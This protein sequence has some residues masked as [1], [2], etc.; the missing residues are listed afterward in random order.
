M[1]HLNRILFALSLGFGLAPSLL[2]AQQLS[3]P[4]SVLPWRALQPEV[5]LALNA[6]VKSTPLKSVASDSPAWLLKKARPLSQQAPAREDL[7]MVETESFENLGYLKS[8]SATQETQS[9]QRNRSSRA[10]SKGSNNW[11]RALRIPANRSGS[12]R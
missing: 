4:A 8:N 11:F 7:P 9:S 6:P 5:K 2:C 10:R 3:Q 12:R 1:R